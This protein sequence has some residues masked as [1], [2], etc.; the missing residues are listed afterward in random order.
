MVT[1]GCSLALNGKKRK[2]NCPIV[3]VNAAYDQPINCASGVVSDFEYV[4]SLPRKGEVIRTVE[5]TP[6]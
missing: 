2:A 5:F 6:R 3:V 4:V 1:G